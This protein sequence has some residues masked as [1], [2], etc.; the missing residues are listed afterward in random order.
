VYLSREQFYTRC[1]ILAE[2]SKVS[3]TENEKLKSLPIRRCVYLSREQFYTQYQ[4]LAETSKVSVTENEKLLNV[5]LIGELRR[6]MSAQTRPARGFF[7]IEELHER[8]L[9]VG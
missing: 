6:I 9:N 5:C 4:I 1:Q 7:R 8:V 2:I 3:V